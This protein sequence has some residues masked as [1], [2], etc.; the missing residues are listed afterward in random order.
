MRLD[1]L[2]KTLSSPRGFLFPASLLVWVVLTAGCMH[3]PVIKPYSTAL[4]SPRRLAKLTQPPALPYYHASDHGYGYHG[5]VWR[6]WPE[7]GLVCQKE[8][9]ASFTTISDQFEDWE[10]E[11]PEPI[12]LTSPGI[13]DW[14]HDLPGDS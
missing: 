6:A 9:P 8:Q 7:D 13:D 2:M 12:P 14:Q 11:H 4:I 3:A 1:G 10:D 5:T